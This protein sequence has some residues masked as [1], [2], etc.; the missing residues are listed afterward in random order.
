MSPKSP[1]QSKTLLTRPSFI[2]AALILA[3]V[4]SVGY[5]VLSRAN[6][7]A[8]DFRNN[9]WSPAHLLVGGRSPYLIESLF[10][11]SNAVWM[12]TVIGAFFPLGWL[13]ESDATAVWTLISIAAYLALLI[14]ASGQQRPAPLLLGVGVGMMLIFP[15]FLS[16]IHLGQVGM[17]TG[18]L[19]LIAARLVVRCA[20]PV[21]IGLLIALASAKPQ[22]LL[23]PVLG[24][25]W[26]IWQEQ[27]TRRAL[28]TTLATC[29]W[30]LLLTLPLWIAYPG[31]IGGFL[32]AQGRRGIW[33]QPS[34]F[35]L[36]PLHLGGVG[37]ALWGLLALMV[38]AISLRQWR[39]LPPERA[40]VWSLALNLLITP[41]VWS[42]D[43]VLLAP[44]FVNVFFA[45]RKRLLR[46][47]LTIGY[48]AIWYIMVAQRLTTNNEDSLYWWL[49][50]AMIVLIVV[51]HALNRRAPQPA[52]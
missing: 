8:W 28:H 13:R 31:W 47:G 38:V 35:V 36:L 9:L 12:P 32:D 19:L 49:P 3:L 30:A 20:S 6:L 44:L 23:L 39:Q 17:L 18:L 26:Y 1:T 29:A 45:L 40:F 16:A 21:W 24:L 25:L 22:L 43:F 51:V 33:S 37:V 4:G 11:G 15:P 46:I 14:L 7:S 52:R 48:M 41:Y 34:A 5:V 27:G 2:A 50:W 42:W 10:P